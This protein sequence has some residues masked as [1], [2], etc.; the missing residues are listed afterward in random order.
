MEQAQ[1][2][3]EEIRN[4]LS[5][6]H[7]ELSLKVGI[8]SEIGTYQAVIDTSNWLLERKPGDEEAQQAIEEANKAISKLRQYLA[9]LESSE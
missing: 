9:L 2:N 6:G 4:S 5:P 1:R 7:Q 8:E 3:A